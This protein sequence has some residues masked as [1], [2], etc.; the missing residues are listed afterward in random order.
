MIL[1][2]ACCNQLAVSKAENNYWDTQPPPPTRSESIQRW[3]LGRPTAGRITI[4]YSSHS[5]TFIALLLLQQPAELVRH[6]VCPT[7]I[8]KIVTWFRIINQPTPHLT[9]PT[10]RNRVREKCIAYK[11]HFHL[12]SFQNHRRDQKRP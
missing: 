3:L 8:F 7:N 5:Y 9:K 12:F 10:K 11:P 6:K 4:T 2:Q 1:L